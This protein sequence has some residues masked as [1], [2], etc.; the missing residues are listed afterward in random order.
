M[1][2]ACVDMPNEP[3]ESDF[4]HKVKSWTG[5]HTEVDPRTFKP[6]R[7]K[8]NEYLLD[9][10]LQRSRASYTGI[11]GIRE[12]PV[13]RTRTG[14]LS[15][16]RSSLASANG[17]QNVRERLPIDVPGPIRVRSLLSS[18]E[19]TRESSVS[20]KDHHAPFPPDTGSRLPRMFSSVVSPQPEGPTTHRN[21]PC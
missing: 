1:D 14:S 4:K 20:E 3:A 13:S 15:G 17:I 18:R 16:D 8:D 9:R 12:A 5:V 11:R 10:S 19:S 6:V 2:G 7:N 21:S